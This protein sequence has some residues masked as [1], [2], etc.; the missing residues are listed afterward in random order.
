MEKPVVL[1]VDDEPGILKSL[2]R[3]LPLAGVSVL[4][5]RSGQEA[6]QL[7]ESRAGVIDLLIVD[8][9]MP[10]MSG[11]EFLHQVNLRHGRKRVIMLSGY[12]NFSG[13]AQ[14][15]NSGEIMRF[16]AKPWSNDELLEAVRSMLFPG[17]AAP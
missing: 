11:D 16:I 4:T 1:C 17:E 8:Q 3:C 2:Q 12:A 5:A 9:R 15:V 13:L 10:D 7:L 6:L 14:A